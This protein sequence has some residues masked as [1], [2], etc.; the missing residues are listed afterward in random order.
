MDLCL[1]L[2]RGTILEVLLEEPYSFRTAGK[3]WQCSNTVTPASVASLLKRIVPVDSVVALDF[4]NGQGNHPWHLSWS[5]IADINVNMA[6][7]SL[8]APFCLCLCTLT[9]NADYA[10]VIV[11]GL[12]L[13]LHRQDGHRFAFVLINRK[14]SPQIFPMLSA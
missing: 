9:Y 10:P 6:Y 8:L 14:D 12:R 4:L 7:V 1:A 3:G 13:Y 5:G 11:P 2:A